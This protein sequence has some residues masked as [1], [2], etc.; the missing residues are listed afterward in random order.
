MRIPVF[1]E[2]QLRALRAET[3]N[4]QDT[5]DGCPIDLFASAPDMLIEEIVQSK[6]T[7][8]RQGDIDLS[9]LPNTF[10]PDFGKIHLSPSR[11]L[12]CV[13]K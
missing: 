10:N 13:A 7:P 5:S 6:P 4:T 1:A 11:R 12:W 2:R 9:E 8:E 3:P